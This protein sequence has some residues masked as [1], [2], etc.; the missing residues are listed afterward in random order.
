MN[1]IENIAD[2]IEKSLEKS[3][4]YLKECQG[5]VEFVRFEVETRVCEIRFKGKCKTCPFNIMTLR[6][7]LEKILLKDIPELRRLEA[8][9]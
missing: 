1:K 6:A 4:P 2:R 8:V 5:D 3:R 9:N 7:G